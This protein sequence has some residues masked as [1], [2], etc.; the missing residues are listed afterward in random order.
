MTLY[1]N[2]RYGVFMNTIYGLICVVFMFLYMVGELTTINGAFELLTDVNPLVPVIVLAA[3]V[4]IYSSFGGVYASLITDAFQSVFALVLIIM[5]SITIAVNIKIPQGAIENVGLLKPTKVGWVTIY[6]MIIALLSSAMFHQGFWQ[7]AFASK[8][9]RDLRISTYIGGSIVFILFT[10]VG[11]F[12]L[13]AAWSGT[14]SA[15]SDIL[16]YQ[17][18]FTLLATMPS[19]VIAITVVIITCLACSALD[20]CMC[21]MIASINDLTYQ[22]MSLRVIRVLVLV[23]MIPVVVV[24]LKQIDVLKIFLLADLMSSATFIPIFIGLIHQFSFIEEFDACVGA[25]GGIL[26]VG[27]FGTIYYGNAKDGWGLLMLPD[28]LYM[29]DYSVLGAFLAAPIGS[30]IFTGLGFCLRS[31]F[32]RFFPRKQQVEQSSEM[33]KI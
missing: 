33:Q 22:K 14:W 30:L 23:I 18:Y 9:N 4:T 17:S 25:I 7:R 13:L 16:G 11:I 10:L 21:A 32:L 27:I 26:S 31:V 24:S 28:G 2:R 5:T 1:L 19:W 29:D 3:V 15:D 20:T 6:V 8:N 12:G